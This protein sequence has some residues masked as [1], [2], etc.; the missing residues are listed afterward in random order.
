MQTP[1][2]R[3]NQRPTHLT[4]TAFGFK[5]KDRL[6]ETGKKL[7]SLAES[8]KLALLLQ[9]CLYNNLYARHQEGALRDTK[10]R[11]RRRLLLV[12]TMVNDRVASRTGKPNGS[13]Q[14]PESINGARNGSG[15]ES[16]LAVVCESIR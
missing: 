1:A 3:G 11:N 6:E 8:L 12:H 14:E 16:Q 2:E 9:D 4:I 10:R 15:I 13:H 5:N 7:S